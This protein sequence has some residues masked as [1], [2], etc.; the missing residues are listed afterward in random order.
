MEGKTGRLVKNQDFCDIT[1]IHTVFYRDR[2]CFLKLTEAAALTNHT[3]FNLL[4]N[5]P[6]F[7]NSTLVPD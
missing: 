5:L 3:L 1:K 6:F 4:C 2:F 7:H